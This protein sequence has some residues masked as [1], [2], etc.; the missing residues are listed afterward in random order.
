MSK[1]TLFLIGL[2]LAGA[3]IGFLGTT[4]F[5]EVTGIFSPRGGILAGLDKL[6]WLVVVVVPGT[7]LGGLSGLIVGLRCRG[8]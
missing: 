1:F 2:S 6:V 5:G 8:R 4:L 7:A 3:C